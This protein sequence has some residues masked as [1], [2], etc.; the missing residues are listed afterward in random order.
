MGAVFEVDA[1]RLPLRLLVNV[2][3]AGSFAKA[4]VSLNYTQ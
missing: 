3:G 4:A 2:A 1:L